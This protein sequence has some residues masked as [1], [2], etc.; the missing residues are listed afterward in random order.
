MSVYFKNFEIENFKG[1]QKLSLRNLA[2]INFILGD[3]NTG[4]TTI[5]EAI[6]AIQYPTE[7]ENYCKILRCLFDNKVTLRHFKEFLP[8]PF[9]PTNNTFTYSFINDFDD[10]FK[11]VVSL[12]FKDFGKDEGILVQIYKNEILEHKV[13]LEKFPVYMT[14]V[15]SLFKYHLIK[16]KYYLNEFDIHYN[17]E[18]NHSLVLND[19]D[20]KNVLLSILQ[21]SD[22]GVEDIYISK[23]DNIMIKT[24]KTR[25]N[26]N[27]MGNGFISIVDTFARIMGAKNG[28]LLLEN[29]DYSLSYEN[30]KI[31]LPFIKKLVEKYNVQ[32]FLS[33][34]DQETMEIFLD[35]E[36]GYLEDISIYTLRKHD[37]KNYVRCLNGVEASADIEVFNLNL[38][39]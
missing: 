17:D 15:H 1:I 16:P 25:M 13:L 9:S 32:L 23:S 12:M 36:T 7:I 21:R 14:S 11:I 10:K 31:V 20:V 37:N 24:S 4:K 28:V 3:N 22:E 39:Y 2:S 33:T 8:Y 5:M 18:I 30:K 26:I 34:Y 19:L 38:L 6:S 27:C 29:W 35:K